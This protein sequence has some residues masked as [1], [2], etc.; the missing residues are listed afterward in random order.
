MFHT[1]RFSVHSGCSLPV[2]RSLSLPGGMAAAPCQYR[3]GHLAAPA[4]RAC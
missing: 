2:P 1:H 3:P 4:L